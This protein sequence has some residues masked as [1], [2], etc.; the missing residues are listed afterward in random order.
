ML[1]SSA[2]LFLTLTVLKIDVSSENT[3]GFNFN[4]LV[5]KR[6][7]RGPSMDLWVTPGKIG[8]R[9]DFP[10]TLLWRRSLTYRT[11]YIGFISKSID[12]FLY[13]RDLRH[14]T[15]KQLFEIVLKDNFQL[16]YNIFLRF[17]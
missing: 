2:L 1:R 10:L 8:L 17:P 12:W 9:E 7:R 3:F 16:I 5:Y 4:P 6:K 11:H 13:D 14:E 15:V